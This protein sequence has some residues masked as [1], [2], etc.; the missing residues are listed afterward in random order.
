MSAVA[1]DV[2]PKFES[3]MQADIQRVF[4][5]QQ[6]KALAL[7]SSNK[8]ERVAKLK[9]LRDAILSRQ[10]AI[11]QACYAEHIKL[12]VQLQLEA[13]HENHGRHQKSQ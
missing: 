9:K 2:H 10:D 12:W 11:Q 13:G 5:L 6:Q 1:Q 8:T 4:A 7:R 3:A